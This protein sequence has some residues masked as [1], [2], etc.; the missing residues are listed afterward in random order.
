MR[1][2]APR[3]GLRVR[4]FTWSWSNIFHRF[5][6]F[7]FWSA[8]FSM[9]WDWIPCKRQKKAAVL[10]VISSYS[11]FIHYCL[12]TPGAK[13]VHV[14]WQ[15]PPLSG[16]NLSGRS[17]EY[18]TEYIIVRS[19]QYPDKSV[20]AADITGRAGHYKIDPSAMDNHAC[21][22]MQNSQPMS[23]PFRRVAALVLWLDPFYVRHSHIL[24]RWSFFVP[25]TNGLRID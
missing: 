1:W 13:F 23:Y 2:K 6:C 7:W 14:I 4:N 15:I 5:W 12:R 9:H 3:N 25:S 18:A 17:E 21:W 11:G 19:N 8:Q 16:K 22:K 24:Y 20:L 10:L